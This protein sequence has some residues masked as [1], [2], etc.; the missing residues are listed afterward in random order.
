MYLI[1][2]LPLQRTGMFASNNK[3]AKFQAL[4][5]SI[6][7]LSLSFSNCRIMESFFYPNLYI[8]NPCSYKFELLTSTIRSKVPKTY[9]VVYGLCLTKESILL[10]KKSIPN[11]ITIYSKFS[12]FLFL[13]CHLFTN[14]KKA[15]FLPSNF[16]CHF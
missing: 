14:T 15:K 6:H 7:F 1:F 8:Y 11:T 10:E 9:W 4:F 2:F 12:F 5:L 16:F 13:F 3:D